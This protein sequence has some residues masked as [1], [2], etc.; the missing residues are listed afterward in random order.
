MPHHFSKWYNSVFTKK[1]TNRHGQKGTCGI[2]YSEMNLPF[3]AKGM[4][5]DLIINPHAIPSRMTIGHLIEC[6][7][8]KLASKKG[9]IADS[10]PFSLDTIDH[11][12]LY[13]TVDDIAAGLSELGLE[14]HGEEVMYNPF[15]GKKY[16]SKIFMGP[17]FYHRLKHMSSEKIHARATGRMEVLRRQP[18]EGRAKDGGLRFGEMERDAV[19]A[20]GAAH[21]LKDRLFYNSDPFQVPVCNNCGQ[22]AINKNGLG[23]VDD[24]LYCKACNV[25]A[26]HISMVAMPYAFKLVASEL[27]ACGIKM[28]LRS[29]Y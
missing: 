29:Q 13:K 11:D 21:F 6:V 15:T 12:G 10:T 14:A 5:P 1:K 16:R 2:V 24:V 4:V 17:T 7:Q 8:S 20:H 3:T 27:R 25:F 18:V 19:L 22:M 23:K 28:D 26:D 9:T